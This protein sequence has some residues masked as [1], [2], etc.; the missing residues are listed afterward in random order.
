MKKAP[1]DHFIQ[2]S[3]SPGTQDCVTKPQKDLLI[4]LVYYQLLPQLCAFFG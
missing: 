4:A 2:R 3:V 1:L